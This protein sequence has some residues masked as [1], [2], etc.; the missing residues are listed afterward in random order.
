MDRLGSA[1]APFANVDARLHLSAAGRPVLTLRNG[2][3]ML[4]PAATPAIDPVAVR[5]VLDEEPF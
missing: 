2:P 5:R 4:V 1:A 3:V